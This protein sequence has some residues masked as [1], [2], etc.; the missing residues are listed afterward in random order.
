MRGVVLAV[1]VV[2]ASPTAAVWSDWED[3]GAPNSDLSFGIAAAGRPNGTL[4][5]FRLS[6]QV[7]HRARPSGGGWGSWT[8]LSSPGGHVVTSIAAAARV[9]GDLDVFAVSHPDG[10]VYH[11]WL[12]PGGTWSSSQWGGLGPVPGGGGG[13]VAAVARA[14]GSL[15]VF[16]SSG[17]LLY[18]KWWFPGGSGWTS[19]AFV[20]G[21][22]GPDAAA[23]RAA[24]QVD[25]VRLSGSN[26]MHRF[27]SSSIGW[28]SWGSL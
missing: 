18:E 10:E 19:W 9:S 25:L 20:A 23:S 8:P 26:V 12:P 5:V 22:G 7:Y 27:W 13:K 4:D 14:N 11:R 2:P 15:G 17:S 16:M 24:G 1:I 28:S 6:D 3:V 21:N